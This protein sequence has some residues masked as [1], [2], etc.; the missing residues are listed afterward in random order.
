MIASLLVPQLISTGAFGRNQFA[1]MLERNARDGL[2]QLVLTS[3]CLF[4]KER[5]VAVYCSDMSGAF[6]KFN[7]RI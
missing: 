1:Y 4:G 2:A 7:F 6:D 5:K 3:L